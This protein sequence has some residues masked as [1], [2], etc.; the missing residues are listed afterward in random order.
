MIVEMGGKWIHFKRLSED[1]NKIISEQK[2]S[3]KIV[4]T[5]LFCFELLHDTE[6]ALNST[7][8]LRAIWCIQG[9]SLEQIEIQKKKKYT[10][11][12]LT[13]Y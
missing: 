2:N 6:Q 4:I 13:R 9:R 5:A 3:D 10:R 12:C 1:S 7:Y 11:A 8:V